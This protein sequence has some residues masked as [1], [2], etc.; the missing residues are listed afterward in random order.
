MSEILDDVTLTLNTTSTISP[1]GFNF[2]L[3]KWV[4][5]INTSPFALRATIGSNA[6]PIPAWSYYPVKVGVGNLRSSIKVL[7]Y[8]QTIPGFNFQSKLS[9]IMY[10]QYEQPD[11]PTPHGLGGTPVGMT[12]GGTA[13]AVQNDGNASQNVVEATLIGNTIGSNLLMVNT[14]DVTVSQY[15]SA[16]LTTL[17]RIITGVAVG[18]SNVLISDANHQAEVLGK[19]LVDGVSG[20]NSL[21]QLFGGFAASGAGVQGLLQPDTN[22]GVGLQITG[23]SGA[24]TGISFVGSF[25][26]TALDMSGI[27]STAKALKF[28]VGSLTKWNIFTGSANNTGTLQAHG[29]GVKPDFVTFQET[30]TAGDANTFIWDIVASD[31]VNVK[32]WTGNATLRTYIALA[33]KQ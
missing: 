10:D 22:S 7:P 4:V 3:V 20:F 13:L 30:G 6:I 14:G 27:P 25:L 33:I 9:T 19:L 32:V 5:F 12:A 26:G 16:V 18:S 15:V 23:N 24:P 8:L 1:A 21:V 31:S 29:L 11:S 2:D 28:P 17:F